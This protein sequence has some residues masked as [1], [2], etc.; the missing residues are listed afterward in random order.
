MNLTSLWD[1]SRQSFSEFWMAR[2]A[3]E[4]AILAVAALVVAFGLAYVLLIAPAVAGREQLNKNLPQL[5]QQAA[6]MQA[7]SKEAAMLSGKAGLAVTGNSAAPLIVISKENIEAALA[8]NGLKAES[9][10]L[11]G[12]FV[13]VLLAA[14]SFSGTL[15]W[16]DDMQKTALFSVVDANIVAL[17]QPDLVNA[18]FTL[19]QPPHE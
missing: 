19:R 5:R 18:T 17:A 15:T 13:K 8:R 11:N 4:R 6:W 7:L 10:M 9:I 3:R 16:L 2:N 1:Q 14:S 12:D